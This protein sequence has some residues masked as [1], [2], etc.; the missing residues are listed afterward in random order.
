MNAD[1]TSKPTKKKKKLGSYRAKA[2]KKSWDHRHTTGNMI[3]N[4]SQMS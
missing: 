3:D 1:L 4:G 2:V